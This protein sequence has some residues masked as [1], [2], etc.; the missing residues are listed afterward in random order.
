MENKSS[1]DP[2]DTD[3]P[4]LHKEIQEDLE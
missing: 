2:M 1:I 3:I 4:G